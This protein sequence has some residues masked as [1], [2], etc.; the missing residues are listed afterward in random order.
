MLFQVLSRH[1]VESCG[2]DK[3]NHKTSNSA[4]MLVGSTSLI[5]GLG[6]RSDGRGIG[7]GDRHDDFFGG[8]GDLIGN[9]RADNLRFNE[10]ATDELG[11]LVLEGGV[12]CAVSYLG[13]LGGGGLLRRCRLGI[14]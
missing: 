2:S 1:L 14:G 6:S 7:S 8:D 3:S 11:G 10:H 4:S 13:G 9:G 5:A 12:G